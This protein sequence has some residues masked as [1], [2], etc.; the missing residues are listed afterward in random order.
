M[1]IKAEPTIAKLVADVDADLVK[2]HD[3]HLSSYNSRLAIS[4]GGQYFTPA[5]TTDTIGIMF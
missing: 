2:K 3:L 4:P 5:T 1:T